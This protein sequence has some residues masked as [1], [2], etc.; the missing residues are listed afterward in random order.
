M[1]PTDRRKAI[2][3]MVRT[4][5][6]DI[7]RDHPLLTL[8]E[9][10]NRLLHGHDCLY[11]TQANVDAQGEC[12]WVIERDASGTPIEIWPMQPNWISDV[13]GHGVPFYI[14]QIPGGSRRGV[15]PEDMIWFRDP[16]PGNPYGRGAGIG[17]AMADELDTDEFAARHIKGYFHHSAMPD[18]MVS[19]EGASKAQIEEAEARWNSKYAGAWN[20]HRLSFTNQK[21]NV[22]TFGDSFKDMQIVELRKNLRDTVIQVFGVPPE[23]LGIVENSN[24]STIDA[25]DLLFAKLVQYPRQERI[26]STLQRSMMADF[27]ASHI[28]M[29]D[30]PIPEDR[31]YQLKVMQANP[32]SVRRA[33]WRETAGFIPDESGADDV[34]VM[35]MGMVE[36]PAGGGEPRIIGDPALAPPPAPPPVALPASPASDSGSKSVGIEELPRAPSI[37]VY[38]AMSPEQIDDLVRSLQPETLR[39]ELDPEFRKLVEQWGRAYLAKLGVGPDSFNMLNPLVTKWLEAESAQKI[40]G[41][42]DTTQN[43]LRAQLTAGVRDGESI[44]DLAKRVQTVFDGADK[45]RA[46]TIARTEVVG[47][48]NFATYSAMAQSGVTHRRAWVA[49][50]DDRTRDEHMAL[51]AKVVDISEPFHIGMDSGMFP[52]DFKQAKNSINCRC[53]TV[54]VLD[55]ESADDIAAE[56]ADKQNHAALWKAYDRKLIPYENS[57]K[58]AVRR[59]FD[60][61]YTEFMKQ[62]R[63]LRS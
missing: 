2:A 26:R 60:S 1:Q 48:S 37:V 24:R 35:P 43:A 17:E 34:Y 4:N 5:D 32:S 29:F 39:Y 25:A 22:Q 30:S 63:T 14:L 11:V 42:N 19:L 56:L 52:G 20:S 8:L 27:D 38:R 6:A 57:I 51:H 40:K 28:L 50:L 54:H 13:P 59:G 7:V 49:T 62:F 36:V 55:G 23:I 33:E 15:L 45:W 16:D 44:D 9:K 18:G 53:T 58:A 21:I 10:G 3:N 41:I 61:Q 46:T 31:E 47:G 12:F